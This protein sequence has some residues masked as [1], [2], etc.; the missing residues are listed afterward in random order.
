M[1]ENQAMMFAT[2][3]GRDIALIATDT[4]TSALR[5]PLFETLKIKETQEALFS[6][7]SDKRYFAILIVYRDHVIADHVRPGQDEKTRN[8]LLW[9]KRKSLIEKTDVGCNKGCKEI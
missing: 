2:T 8:Q 1:Y 7:L 4:F 3:Q 9:P 6:R 5:A